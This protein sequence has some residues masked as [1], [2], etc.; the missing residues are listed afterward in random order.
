MSYPEKATTESTLGAILLLARIEALLGIPN[1]VQLHMGAIKE[2]L[3]VC[4]RLGVYL[5]DGIKRA[6]FW[7]D[8][9]A[10]VMTGSRRIV[11]HTTF[12]ELEWKRDPFAPNFFILP[13]GFQ[14]H[15]ALLGES[16]LDILRDI[17]ALQCIRDSALFGQEDV[18]SMAHIDNHQASIQSRLSYIS[19]QLLSEIQNTNNDTLW[20]TSPD[21]L[22][23]LLHIGGAFAPSLNIGNMQINHRIGMAPLTRLRAS[24]D[25]VPT[26]LMKEYYSQRAA[27]PGT[28]IITEGTF[29]SATCGG[30][31]HAPGLWHEEQVTA[32]KPITDEVHRK[33]CFIFCQLF[34][35]GRAADV[36]IARR[37]G[38]DIVA[39]SAIPIEEGAPVPRAMTLDEI[40]QTVR[41][42]VDASKNAIR[43]GFDGVEI[44]GANGYL[45]DQFIQDVS[46][47]RTDQYGGSV[48]NRNR[49]VQEVIESVVDAIGSKCVGLRLS[50]WSTFQGMRMVDPIPQFSNL[51]NKA[52]QFDLAYLHLVESR[53]SGASES[54][55]H[56]SLDFAY[57]LWNGLFLVA[58]GYTLQ[59]AHELVEKRGS[60][61]I[62]VIFG[63]YF[64]S[65][66]DLVYRAKR[67]LELSAYN[68]ETF[69][70]SGSAVGYSDYPFSAGYLESETTV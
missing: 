62:M 60:K 70:V 47:D 35:M 37:E 34:A 8:L 52:N 14:Q 16:F 40:K 21:L 3:G 24:Q 27:V 49:L 56:E 25:R 42:F 15:A 33:G 64:I 50:P 43:A 67:G 53:I 1:H 29:I 48:E 68:R 59:E 63:R 19:S 31:P 46:N 51:I 55:G 39:P 57:D 2:I 10:S 6:I 58:G 45:L 26:P 36:E 12:A 4:Q 11:D 5:S 69:Y 38:V 17:F 28:L 41:E 23:W 20:D 66:P 9:N 54:V 7:T 61:D 13:P 65:N 44:H 32:W 18:I 22:A 30:F